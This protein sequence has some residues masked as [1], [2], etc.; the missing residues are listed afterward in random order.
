MQ[1]KLRGSARL[2][3]LL[4]RLLMPQIACYPGAY[5]PAHSH[6]HTHKHTHTDI[7]THSALT[8]R[9]K[10]MHFRL[11]TFGFAAIHVSQRLHQIEKRYN[12]ESR[13]WSQAW[14]R[15]RSIC[16]AGGEGGERVWTRSVGSHCSLSRNPNSICNYHSHSQQHD[17]TNLP[18][19][20]WQLAT[21]NRQTP[22]PLP[23]PSQSQLHSPSQL[24]QARQF[25]C[26]I[27]L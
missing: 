20:N 12:F 11:F 13:L 1:H 16:V 2:L 23:L 24:Q 22:L 17:M 7:H 18:A 6:T 14:G 25:N 15:G 19:S 8:S 10:R 27:R 3:L 4:L 5:T 9:L 26:H 21:G